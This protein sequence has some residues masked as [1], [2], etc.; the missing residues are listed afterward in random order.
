MRVEAV[1]VE[2]GERGPTVESIRHFRPTGEPD[3]PF[4]SFREH[5]I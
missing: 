4:E 5:L 2:P 1:W 3:A